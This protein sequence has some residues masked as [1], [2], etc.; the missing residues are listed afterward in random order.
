MRDTRII[1]G[2]PVTV[3]IVD[4]NANQ[5]DLNKIFDYFHY[6]DEKFSTYKPT[7]EISLINQGKIAEAD[8]SQDM[9]TVLALSEQTKKETQ[10]YFDI[11]RNGKLDPSGLVKGW[12]IFN[13]SEILKK[14]GFK[15]YFVDAGGDVQVSG[16]N[17]DNTNWQVG[18][19]NPFN[20]KEII[21]VLNLNNCGVATSGTYIRGQHIYNPKDPNKNI[22]DIVSLTVVGPNVYEAD[23]FATPAFAMGKEG[24]NFIESLPG[25]EGY[26]INKDGIA[27]M[28]SGFEKYTSFTN[29]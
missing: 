6:V 4:G 11:S 8:Q 2:M 12:A 20:E 27:T 29:Y 25:L 14:S 24:I 15:N 9:K 19:K 1:M 28:T 3:E 10:G 26:I 22:T 21:K 23:R 17:S 5:N 13:A 18:I 16:K 7:S